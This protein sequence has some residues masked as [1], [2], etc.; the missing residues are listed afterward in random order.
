MK[1]LITILLTTIMLLCLAIPVAAKVAGLPVIFLDSPDIVI[2]EE[3]VKALINNNLEE[4]SA[5]SV[6]LVP[7]APGDKTELYSPYGPNYLA[8]SSDYKEITIK[9]DGKDISTITID[10]TGKLIIPKDSNELNNKEEIIIE[11]LYFDKTDKVASVSKGDTK[12]KTITSVKYTDFVIGKGI[13][14]YRLETP[15]QLYDV[16]GHVK[17]IE[18]IELLIKNEGTG[19]IKVNGI[20]YK[21]NRFYA[22]PATLLSWTWEDIANLQAGIEEDFTPCYEFSVRVN[23]FVGSQTFFSIDPTIVAS[24][25]AAGWTSVNVSAIV[26]AGAT[27]AIVHITI[28]P[29]AQTAVGW[30]KTGSTDA[31]IQ[32]W[33]SNAIR[34]S[35]MWTPV[36]LDV[37]RSFD[38]YDVANRVQVRLV[39]YTISGVTMLTN[40]TDNSTAT[41]GSWQK[42]Y[43]N[44]PSATGLIF[45]VI[46][47]TGGNPA[48]DFRKNGSTDWRFNDGMLGTL[49]RHSAAVV[50]CDASQITEQYIS[51][52]S[53]D[54][55]LTGYIT[56]G[57]VFYTNSVNISLPDNGNEWID[58]TAFPANTGFGFINVMTSN[59]PTEFGLRENGSTENITGMATGDCHSFGIVA[60]NN[61]TWDIEGFT[62]YTAHVGFYVNGYTELPSSVTPVVDVVNTSNVTNNAADVQ[63]DLQSLG[64]G[65]VIEIGVSWNET[66]QADPVANTP[67]DT[68]GSNVTVNSDAFAV[69][70]Y[71]IPID[72]LSANTTWWG[73]A[74]AKNGDG[75]NWSDNQT[76][77]TT[78]PPPNVTTNNI[79]D[80]AVESVSLNG[81]IV[82]TYNVTA[83]QYG[84]VYDTDSAFPYANTVSF[85]GTH[86]VGSYTYSLGW[87]INTTGYYRFF[88]ESVAGKQYGAEITFTTLDAALAT[89]DTVASAGITTTN[90][91]MFA[92]ITSTGSVN[93]TIEGFLYGTAPGVYTASVNNTGVFGLGSYNITISSLAA[94]TD[95][96]F[97]AFVTNAMG[98]N[99]GG[100]LTFTTT[101]SGG[102]GSSNVTT[103]AYIEFIY[104]EVI[105]M[106]NWILFAVL[107][108]FACGLLMASRVYSDILL[109]IITI[110]SWWIAIAW[111]NATVGT[112]EIWQW[113][114]ILLFTG[115][116]FLPAIWHMWYEVKNGK[117]VKKSAINLN[118]EDI[119]KHK[120]WLSGLNNRKERN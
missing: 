72:L 89:V 84:F 16:S 15:P 71:T 13:D 97:V 20:E 38:Y 82:D 41:V 87:S 10:G 46:D 62:A 55:F 96:Y 12:T 83:T 95:Y 35:H 112:A 101:A 50:G 11:P 58:L 117:L 39:G 7:I 111:F 102:G 107:L 18:S 69:G 109:R 77:F 37:N 93:V 30:R 67:P 42:I 92:T 32:T 5:A 45:E 86:S 6:V 33:E 110:G 19:V 60:A 52:T 65:T 49:Y 26:P 98:T 29:V 80:Q 91:T 66:S 113:G 94:G 54:V 90:A 14:L 74:Y 47:A 34:Y 31:R 103:D 27:G 2:N 40:A 57:A 28:L 81:E 61:I 70:L 44:A 1:K 56:D 59:W 119:E 105:D 100:E 75:Y 22:N 21:G 88:A 48:Y 63:I 108:A 23:F 25:S 4:L 17:W 120:V 106:A 3:E 78:S 68:Y 118:E 53:A 116:S 76:V 114:I 104:G 24:G 79:T 73:R 85:N 64:G 51:A 8:V 9:D 43:A 36:G 99:Y 115:I